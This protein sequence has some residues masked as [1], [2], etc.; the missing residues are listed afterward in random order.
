MFNLKNWSDTY[1]NELRH[2]LSDVNFIILPLDRTYFSQWLFISILEK[3]FQYFPIQLM[4]LEKLSFSISKRSYQL[5]NTLKKMDLNFDWVIAHNPAAFYPALYVSHNSKARM[6]LDNEDYHSGEG[7]DKKLNSRKAKL[8]YNILPSAEYCSYSSPLI[9][10]KV[11]HDIPIMDSMQLVV[12]NSFPAIEF[13]EPPV[14]DSAALQLVWFSQNIDFG[15]GLEPIIEAVNILSPHVELHLIGNLRDSF[16]KKVLNGKKGFHLHGTMNQCSLHAFLAK[17]DIGLALEIPI[18]K[19]K[20][21]AISN[22][23]IS[24]VQSGMFILASHT[25]AQDYFLSKYSI[26]CSQFDSNIDS[27]VSSLKLLISQKNQI[28]ATRQKRFN[29]GKQFSWENI[30]Y[31]LVQIWNNKAAD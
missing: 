10:Q 4:S 2:Q 22:K 8:M 6:A 28:R 11:Q 18:D 19:N 7:E 13:I 20:D 9:M 24:Y 30:S 16:Y 26:E 23:I 21:L 15:R 27:V 3:I 29:S 17:F 12:L 1:D 25:A 31:T 5:I 14:I